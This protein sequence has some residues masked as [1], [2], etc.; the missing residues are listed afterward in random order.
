MV[1]TESALMPDSS[2]Q[3]L[4]QS[5]KRILIIEDDPVLAR[6]YQNRIAKAGFT[7]SLS[8]DGQDGFFSI[9]QSKPDAVLLDLMLPHIDG[10]QILRK[11]R[12]QK[13]F[14]RMPIIVFSNSYMNGMLQQAVEA[15]ATMVVNKSERGA[16]ENIVASFVQML[17]GPV[18]QPSETIS[19]PAENAP[20]AS[21]PPSDTSF[22]PRFSPQSNA[23]PTAEPAVAT[24]TAAI[25][26]SS[27]AAVAEAKTVAP[28]S[29]FGVI[30]IAQSRAAAPAPVVSRV[31]TPRTSDV[32]SVARPLVQTGTTNVD[33]LISANRSS[34]SKA[35]ETA[36][37]ASSVSSE[38]PSAEKEVL[39]VFWNNGS[40]IMS[41]I[42]TRMRAYSK[43]P[44]TDQGREHLQAFYRLVRSLTSAAAMASVESIANF[45]ACLE[46]LLHELNNKPESF[47][48]STLR[49]LAS[50]VDVLDRMFKEAGR[51][52]C[53]M[54]TEAFVLIVDDDVVSQR[55]VTLSLQKARLHVICASDADSAL[56]SLKEISF[57]LIVLDVNMPG[58]DGFE[59]CSIIRKIPSYEKTPIL[60]VSGLTDFASRARSIATGGNDFICKP[61]NRIEM[62]VKSLSYVMKGRLPATEEASVLPP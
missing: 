38:L 24:R 15:G 36:G 2:D 28:K 13:Q 23:A 25:E 26:T 22:R 21:Q 7:V 44:Q 19:T 54:M 14:E 56:E 60:F 16:V 29:R 53:P 32:V 49:T 47:Q 46:A 8:S 9:M 27:Q 17:C 48:A 33:Q 5:G 6:V 35:K 58:L 3:P 59:V 45:T 42:R 43:A 52:E 12:A 31:E 40:E 57:E 1:R 61:L 34:Q 50:A 10:L 62:T 20:A 11:T 18:P 39:E 41:R 4:A 37:A 51:Y 30:P 55:A